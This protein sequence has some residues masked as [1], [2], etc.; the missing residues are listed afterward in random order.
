[1]GTPKMF[2]NRELY[3]NSTAYIYKQQNLTLKKN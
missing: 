1:M 2:K 3:Y